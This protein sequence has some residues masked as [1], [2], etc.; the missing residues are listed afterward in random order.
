MC[1]IVTALMAAR[2]DGNA[3]KMACIPLAM[4]VDLV[5]MARRQV[6]DIESGIEE[7]IYDAAENLDIGQ[8]RSQLDVAETLCREAENDSDAMAR[9]IVESV[10]MQ[11]LIGDYDTPDGISEWSW[12]ER[13]ASL[14]HTRNGEAGIWEFMLNL[15]RTFEDI[16]SRLVTTIDKARENGVAYL[17]FHQGT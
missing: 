11:D 12:V 2:E 6:E 4:L 14:S 8:K 15:S 5:E 9:E 10:M 13:N 16:P 1:S 7:G 17:M 3:E